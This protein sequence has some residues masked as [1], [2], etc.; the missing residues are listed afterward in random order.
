[1]FEIP[2]KICLSQNNWYCV[3]SHVSLTYS[4]VHPSHYHPHALCNVTHH[5]RDYKTKPFRKSPS[6]LTSQTP[7][8]QI[9]NSRDKPMTFFNV[10]HLLI[11]MAHACLCLLLFSNV[12]FLLDVLSDTPPPLYFLWLG[13]EE[14]APLLCASG[15]L[16]RLQCSCLFFII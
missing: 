1:M 2:A 8:M 4:P 5:T 12:I 11:Q 7:D 9:L 6:C 16:M 15:T 3:Q 14:G 10:L 13:Q